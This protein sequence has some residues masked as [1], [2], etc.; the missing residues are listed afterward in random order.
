MK[1]ISWICRFCTLFCTVTR[2]R[3]SV[4]VSVRS[5]LGFIVNYNNLIWLQGIFSSLVITV[6]QRLPGE[7]DFWSSSQSLACKMQSQFSGLSHNPGQKYRLPP[8]T[9][10]S[11][12]DSALRQYCTATR[13]NSQVQC[14]PVLLWSSSMQCWIRTLRE[15]KATT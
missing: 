3:A 8:E 5:S 6:F 11:L 7:T 13:A 2:R 9:R 12:L 10:T 4:K 14:H 1:T 15:K